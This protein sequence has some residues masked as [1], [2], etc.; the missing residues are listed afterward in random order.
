VQLG[1]AGE[2]KVEVTSGLARGQEILT[3][4]FKILRTLKDGSQVKVEKEKKGGEGS[5]SAG[6]SS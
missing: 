4:P 5:E 6:G 3:G 2:L 1:L